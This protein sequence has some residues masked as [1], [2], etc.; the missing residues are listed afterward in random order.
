MRSA[1]LKMTMREIMGLVTIAVVLFASSLQFFDRKL[2][3]PQEMLTKSELWNVL[4]K[5]PAVSEI[6]IQGELVVIKYQRPLTNHRSSPLT[7]RGYIDRDGSVRDNLEFNAHFHPIF[8]SPARPNLWIT[9]LV[10]LI[11]PVAYVILR[12]VA[13]RVAPKFLWSQKKKCVANYMYCFTSI[14]PCLSMQR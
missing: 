4:K 5:D 9:T 7:V 8:Y 14:Q 11:L 6:E 3:A 2:P 13:Q 10:I 1:N 12:T